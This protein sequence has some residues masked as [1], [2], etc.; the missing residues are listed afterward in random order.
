MQAEQQKTG[1][2]FEGLDPSPLGELM[3]R[4]RGQN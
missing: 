1:F 4:G 2:Q 3:G